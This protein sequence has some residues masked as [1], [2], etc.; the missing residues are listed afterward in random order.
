MQHGVAALCLDGIQKIENLSVSSSIPMPKQCK[1]QWI[2]AVMQQERQFV[3]QMQV[4]KHLSCFYSKNNI[5]MMLLKGYGC[6]LNYPIP[7]ID[8]VE[9]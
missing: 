9:M 2:G 5:K 3:K 1:M 7:I 6:S 8:H 4:L